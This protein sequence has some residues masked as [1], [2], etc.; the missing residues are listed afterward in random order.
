MLI[1]QFQDILLRSQ[2]DAH[3]PS[4]PRSTFDLKTRATLAIRKDIKMASSNTWYE[5]TD[6]LGKIESFEREYYDMLRASFL[7][8]SLQVRI[9]NMGGIFVAY[10]NIDTVFGF[11][12]ISLEE[13]EEKMFGSEV[14]GEQ[15]F[16]LSTQILNL[17]LKKVVEEFP[18]QDSQVMVSKPK[19]GTFTMYIQPS[20]PNPGQIPIEVEVKISSYVN[21]VL[22]PE[23]L[24]KKNDI[25]T[26][27]LEV[28]KIEYDTLQHT[29][30]KKQYDKLFAGGSSRFGGSFI[31]T[32]KEEVRLKRLRMGQPEIKEVGEEK[33][34]G[35]EL[36][37]EQLRIDK[38]EE[39]RKIYE[40]VSKD[41]DEIQQQNP[42]MEKKEA[43]KLFKKLVKVELELRAANDRA[44]DK[45]A[46]ER[47]K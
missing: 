42:S 25:W 11:E 14:M 23:P 4:V 20:N 12:Y 44:Q 15:V 6:K 2:L 9:G 13:M 21:G 43:S 34:E 29:S 28:R 30:A 22:T 26:V 46:Y 24:I 45:V 32:L 27:E 16:S 41:V 40:K 3:D 7:K 31:R 37:R 10:H 33:L 47:S 18:E 5:I 19:R 39:R 1:L 36:I 17:L 8:Y 35:A 38:G